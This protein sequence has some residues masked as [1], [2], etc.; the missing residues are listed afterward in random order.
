MTDKTM[1]QNQK[2]AFFQLML[3]FLWLVWGLGGCAWLWG[4]RYHTAEQLA[5]KGMEEFE[6][7]D[8]GDALKTF[9][10][11]KERYPYSRYAILAEL[12]VAD[13]HYYRAE[14]PE[15]IAAY[16]DFVRLHPKNE[17]IPYV[18]FQVGAC[19]HEQLLSVDRDQ[20]ATRKSILAFERLL[21][22]HPKSNYARKAR[23]RIRE[24]RELLAE[25]EVYVGRFYYKAKHYRAALGRF[26]GVLEYYSD[27]LS[28]D[29]QQEV[30]D[31]IV[32]CKRKLAEA[33]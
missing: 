5:A 8:Y 7:E 3:L 17:V 9:S 1:Q 31:F 6:N 24:C 23:I 14:Y 15:A 27:A 29:E 26:E 28:A 10:A 33:E 30:K 11:L 4:D 19:Y 22:A 25:H 20:T 18:L 32:F 2:V 21:K 13:A 12:K 16:E